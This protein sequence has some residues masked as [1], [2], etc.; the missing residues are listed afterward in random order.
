MNFNEWENQ[1]KNA[2]LIK[3]KKIDSSRELKILDVGIF[4]WHSS[5]ELS[6]FYIGDNYEDDIAAWPNYNFSHEE[7]GEWPEVE[8][9]CKSM[10]AQYLKNTET[11]NTFF[12]CTAKIMKSKEV[13]DLL[14]T[15]K[16]SSEFRVDVLDPDSDENFMKNQLSYE[17]RYN[18][19]KS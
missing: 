18:K 10:N 1:L 11:K 14:K 9:I 3:L 16:L 6:A 19:I 13:I 5:I 12:K 15:K 17:Y 2:L 7:E 4:P 8:Q